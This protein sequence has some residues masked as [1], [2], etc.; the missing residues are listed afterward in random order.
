[1]RFSSPSAALIVAALFTPT[2][3]AAKDIDVIRPGDQAMSC[4]AL[5]A[6][7]NA[8]TRTTTKQQQRAASRGS[9]GGLGGLFGA[10][11]P[12]AAPVLDRVYAE[13]SG[14]TATA[15]IV[16]R[17]TLERSQSGASA[18]PRAAPAAAPPSLEAQRLQRLTTIH[19]TKHC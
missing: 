18:I 1:M 10:L 17:D 6:E 14:R 16:A 2:P 7:I 5:G 11:A 3:I 19:T 8:L 12:V 4:N 13:S 15:A 9:G